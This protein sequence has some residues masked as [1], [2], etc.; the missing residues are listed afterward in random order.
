MTRKEGRELQLPPTLSLQ[1]VKEPASPV[2]PGYAKNQ[3]W[4]QTSCGRVNESDQYHIHH[5]DFG[6]SPENVVTFGSFSSLH[7]RKSEK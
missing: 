6:T 3:S 2:D 4:P 5:A 1:N 7:S